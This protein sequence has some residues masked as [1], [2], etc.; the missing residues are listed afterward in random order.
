MSKV[1]KILI[2][3]VVIAVFAVGGFAV[4]FANRGD[5]PLEAELPAVETTVS[6]GV[7][8]GTTT[9]DTTGTATGAE[10]TWSVQPGNRDDLFVGYQ[11]EETLRGI[12][13]TAT[14]KA[15][16]Y[17][18]SLTIEGDTV[19]ALDLTVDMTSLESDES[20]R[21]DSQADRGLEINQFPDANFTITQSVELATAPARGV[22]V[23]V[24]ATGNLTLHGITQSVTIPVTARWNGDTIDVAGEIPITLADYDISPPKSGFVSVRD[25]GK[26]V[27]VVRFARS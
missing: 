20:R 23:T 3:L 27:F 4:W 19:A 16:A 12:D 13:A 10:G 18:G 17:T 6:T 22:E 24:E 25:E 7:S 2:S 1:T 21:D 26:V 5:D 15:D 11:I 9:G 14:G 8:S